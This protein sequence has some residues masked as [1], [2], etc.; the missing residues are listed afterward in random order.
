MQ[1]DSKYKKGKM[2]E[3][4]YVYTN[5][6]EMPKVILKVRANVMDVFHLQKHGADAIFFEPCARCHI[7]KGRGLSG[8]NLFFADCIMCHRLGSI[9]PSLS[10][11]EKLPREE[12]KKAIM[13][14]VPE[15][16]MPPFLDDLGGPLKRSDIKSLI[17]YIKGSKR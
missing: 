1:I 6:P 12:L 17:N 14:G 16:R 10:K 13:Q 8:K 9:G 11:L 5:D 15:T 3:M 4:V 7:D 2:V